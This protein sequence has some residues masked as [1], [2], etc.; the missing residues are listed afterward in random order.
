MSE[1]ILIKYENCYINN[2]DVTSRI[3]WNGN[4]IFIVPFGE[5]PVELMNEK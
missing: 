1:F 3:F 2:F 4:S 5:S